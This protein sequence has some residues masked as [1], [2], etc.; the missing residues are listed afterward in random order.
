[1]LLNNNIKPLGEVIKG[2][3][4]TAH[5]Y[6][7]VIQFYLSLSSDFKVAADTSGPS[8]DTVRDVATKQKLNPKKKE[9]LL[10]GVRCDL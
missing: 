1:M 2:V 7:D 4:A 10:E 6:A 9:V 3:L 8:P 5:Q